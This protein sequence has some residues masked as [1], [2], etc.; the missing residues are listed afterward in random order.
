MTMTSQAGSQKTKHNHSCVPAPLSPIYQYLPMQRI[1]TTE[2]AEQTEKGTLS[3]EEVREKD[4]IFKYPYIGRGWFVIRC[5]G[6]S[7]RIHHFTSYPMRNKL[8]VNHFRTSNPPEKCH[9]E[10]IAGTYTQNEIVRK[11][12]YQVTDIHPEDDALVKQSN[13]SLVRRNHIIITPTSPTTGAAAAGRVRPEIG[14]TRRQPLGGGSSS[15]GTAPVADMGLKHDTSSSAGDN[16][17]GGGG[18]DSEDLYDWVRKGIS[19][20]SFVYL[21]QIELPRY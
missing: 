6:N 3:Y 12:G 17:A 19:R 11:F 15:S 7:G 4:H 8:V 18:G 10:D 1:L 14:P 16:D 9:G 13:D 2:T 20:L 5:D 21:S